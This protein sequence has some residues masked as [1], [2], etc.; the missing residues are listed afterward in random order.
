MN[1]R[2][3]PTGAFAFMCMSLLPH[4][5]QIESVANLFAFRFPDP[6]WGRSSR[7]D[8]RR[9]SLWIEGPSVCLSLA[10]YLFVRS[11]P[12]SSCPPAGEINIDN[13]HAREKPRKHEEN[14]EESKRTDTHA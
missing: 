5:L 4:D 14:K 6:V 11:R 9:V 13:Q 10:I 1:R 12:F 2:R 7:V 3:R 8:A